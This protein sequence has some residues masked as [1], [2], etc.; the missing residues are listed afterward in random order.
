MASQ[1]P[2]KSGMQ[3]Y[4]VLTPLK[5]SDGGIVLIDRG[6][7]PLG[8]TRQ[9]LPELAVDEQSRSITGL[10]DELPRPGVR[11]GNAGLGSSWPQ[12]LNYPR[13]NELRS[14]FGDSLQSRIVLLDADQSDGFER[15]WQ[16]NTGFG[17]ERHVGYA[18][19]WFGLATALVVIYIIVNLRK[20]PAP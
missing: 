18:V 2:A 19:Q 15:R 5:L 6:W 16:I 1:D 20:I 8:T 7:L 9:Q 3:G 13:D 17:P 12:V 14:L 11:A 4:R 10:L